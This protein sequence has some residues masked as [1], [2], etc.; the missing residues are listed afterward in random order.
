MLA[1]DGLGGGRENPLPD[2]VDPV[3]ENAFAEVQAQGGN[4]VI[5]A[6]Q[7]GALV[8]TL[9]FIVLPCLSHRGTRRAQLE[10]V[11]VSAKLRGQGIGEA[12]LRYAID[13]AK[14]EGCGLLQLSSDKR[15]G[16]AHLF[17][18]RLGFIATH[19]GFRLELK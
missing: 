9:Q 14:A 6:E 11:R 16:R 12:M 1:D 2:G 3:Y 8:G 17:Y 4:R 7:D 19:V 10:A 15:R 5:V 18:E 13:L